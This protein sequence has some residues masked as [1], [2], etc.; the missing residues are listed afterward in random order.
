[1]AL[2]AGCVNTASVP[3][4]R[5]E[6]LAKPEGY[7]VEIFDSATLKRPYKVIGIVQASAG[8]LRSS[9]SVI[10]HLQAEA[11]QMGG[12]ALI[13]LVQ[14]VAEESVVAPLGIGFI[15]SNAGEIWSAKVIV[16]Q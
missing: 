8:L 11:G 7:L 5:T 1:M 13:D 9:Q 14:G 16:W 12:D 3:Y 15:Y 4:D 10:E 6:H 2:L